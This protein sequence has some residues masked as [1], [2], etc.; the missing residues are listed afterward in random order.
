M[1]GEVGVSGVIAKTSFLA[2]LRSKNEVFLEANKFVH[3]T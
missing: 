1:V 3:C 2:G